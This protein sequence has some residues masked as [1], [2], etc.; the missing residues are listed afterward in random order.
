M[1]RTV[2]AYLRS[3]RYSKKTDRVSLLL[4]LPDWAFWDDKDRK[5]F[6]MAP[7]KLTLILWDHNER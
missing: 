7:G 3:Y 6:V 2:P 4:E 1:G 5:A